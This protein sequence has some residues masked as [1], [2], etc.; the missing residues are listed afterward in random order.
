[1]SMHRRIIIFFWRRH[2]VEPAVRLS[3]SSIILLLRLLAA[4]AAACWPAGAVRLPPGGTQHARAP[5]G[6]PRVV[7]RQRVPSARRAFRPLVVPRMDRA[8]KRRR[9]PRRA[10]PYYNTLMRD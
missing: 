3:A 5:A 1:M 2:A 6:A 9:R 8:P 7:C 4:C 10:A